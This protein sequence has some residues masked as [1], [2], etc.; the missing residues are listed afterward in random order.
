MQRLKDKVALVTGASRGIGKAVALSFA[1]EGA[2]VCLNFSQSRDKADALV[3]EINGFSVRAVAYQAN[4][5]NRDEVARMVS[6]AVREFGHIDILVNNAGIVIPGDVF[7]MNDDQLLEMYKVNVMGV[8]NCTRLIA[9]HMTERKYGKI[10][11]IGSI[12]GIGTNYL[13]TTPYSSTKASVMV[14]TKRFALE[15]GTYG[16]NVNTVAPGF[17]ETELNTRGKSPEEWRKKVAEM[18]EKAMLRKIGQPED[19]A[20][21]VLFLAS[22]DSSFITA[23][24]LVVDGGRL[25]YLSHSL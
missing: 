11:N 1:R 22:D 2:S 4:V 19:I 9:K 16:I 25:D 10:V 8:I 17:I 5:A 14:L 20:S 18:S 7:S 6:A 12:A 21:A 3:K 24:T 15:L 23:Q 13:G